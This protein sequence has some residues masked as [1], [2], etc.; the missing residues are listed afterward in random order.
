MTR[1]VLKILKSCVVRKKHF[2]RADLRFS[3]SLF[4]VECINVKKAPVHYKKN[5]VLEPAAG[6]KK[7]CFLTVQNTEM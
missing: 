2:L 3:V 1:R 4:R 5:L 7:K 6:G